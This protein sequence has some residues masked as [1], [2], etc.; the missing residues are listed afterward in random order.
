MVAS[1]S[2]SKG[3]VSRDKGAMIRLA[4][5]TY[6]RVLEQARRLGYTVLHEGEYGCYVCAEVTRNTLR[7][8]VHHWYVCQ[9]HAKEIGVLW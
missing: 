6:S 1:R 4:E 5:A 9:Y 7:A 3:A 8:N 2:A